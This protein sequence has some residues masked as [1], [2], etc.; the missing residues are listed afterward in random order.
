MSS[1]RQWM[2]NRMRGGYLNPN[3]VMECTFLF[4]LQLVNQN[5]LMD[6]E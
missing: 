5:G 6:R 1:D 3:F 2:Y 4:N